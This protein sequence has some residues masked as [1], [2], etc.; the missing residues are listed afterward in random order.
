MRKKWL[1]YAVAWNITH[2]PTFTC[3]SQLSWRPACRIFD[4]WV[5]N[6]TGMKCPL[7]W[8][9]QPEK[10]NTGLLESLQQH[11]TK[12]KGKRWVKKY[13]LGHGLLLK[14]ENNRIEFQTR[15]IK[16]YIVSVT[17]NFILK[18]LSFTFLSHVFLDCT[19]N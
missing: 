17:T 6:E 3:I 4:R 18:Y 9:N 10:N 11:Q 7:K 13:W 8:H 16:K 14:M 5:E 12:W 15:D 2:C 1:T 19:C